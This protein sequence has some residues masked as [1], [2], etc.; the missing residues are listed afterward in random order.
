MA[1]ASPFSGFLAYARLELGLSVNTLRNYRTA[2]ERL[3]RLRE[4]R[5]FAALG[6]AEIAGFLGRLR[7]QDRLAPA[8]LALTL[9]AWRMFSRWL[10]M[11]G[12]LKEDRIALAALPET[13]SRLPGV[14]SEDEV[15]RLLES[16]PP[17]DLQRRDR[18]ALELLYALGGRASEVVGLGL[19]DLREERTLALLH[20]KGGKDRLVPLGERA[21]IAV[22][23][24]L[25]HLRPTLVGPDSDDRLLLTTRGLPMPRQAL[26]RLVRDAGRLAGLGRPVWTHLLR[27]TFATHL[28]TRGADLRAV[29]ELLGHSDLAT[30]QRYTRV[31]A[32]RLK[33]IHQRFHPRA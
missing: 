8:T 5:D 21:R 31:D 11:E 17:G 30:T 3:E 19:G 7:D 2:L 9:V 32:A 27:H 25:E 29:Q 1:Q 4:G 20:G 23:E 14:L 26:W 10:V 28:L 15:A 13:W 18:C 33:A 24:Y 12:R 22:A 6:P 16:A